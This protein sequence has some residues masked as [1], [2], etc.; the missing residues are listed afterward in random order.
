MVGLGKMG[1]NMTRR[2]LRGGHEV[3]AYNRSPEPIRKAEEEGAEGASTLEDLVKALELPRVVWV[4]VPAG[5]PTA[6]VLSQLEGILDGGDIV[7]DGGNSKWKD[8]IERAGHLRTAGIELLDAGTSGG[9]WGLEAGYCLM[10]GGAR[11]AFE[12]VEPALEALAPEGG[13][14]HVGGSG[15]GHFVKMIHNGIEYGIM[16]SYGEGFEILERSEYDL[17]LRSIASLWNRGSVIRSWLLELAER[18]LEEDPR[19]EGVGAYVEDS[20][21]GR[22]SV[23]AAIHE[24]V[25]APAMAAALFARFYSRLDDSFSAKMIAALRDQFGGHGTQ[26]PEGS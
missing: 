19:L 2:L 1:L 26:K 14:A 6:S 12:T 4:M 21:E 18:A 5:D 3:V 11:G 22:W 24:A 16:Q 13:Y 8:T 15:A 10:V 7:V 20:G 17:D 9:V 25:P 23:Q